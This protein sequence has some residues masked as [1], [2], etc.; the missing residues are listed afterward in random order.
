MT[1]R[2]SPVFQNHAVL[3]RDISIPIWGDTE[4]MHQVRCTFGRSVA[5]TVS[6]SSGRFE[7]RFP[8]QAAGGPHELIFE[9]LQSGE[10]VAFSDI[11]VGE[12]YVASGQSNIA[13]PLSDL[14]N[15]EVIKNSGRLSNPNIHY[16]KV[17]MSALP[18]PASYLDGEWTTATDAVS[19]QF[20]G[21]G[22]LFAEKIAAE[23]NIKV[24]IIEAARGG[25]AAESWMSREA[26]LR[27]PNWAEKVLE[28]DNILFGTGIYNMLPPGQLLPKPDELIMNRL[29]DQMTKLPMNRGLSLGYAAP[30]FDDRYWRTLELPDSW[31]LAGYIHG[32]I[33][34]FRLTLDLPKDCAGKE[35]TLSLGAVDK[36]DLTYFNGTE[37]GR[38]GD[39]IDMNFWDRPR[40]YTAPGEL[41][42]AGRNVI[43]IRVS[44][45]FPVA[46]SGGLTGPADLMFAKVGDLQIPLN[47]EWRYHMEHNAGNNLAESLV[48]SG[49]GEPHS[50]HILFDNMIAP[51]IPYAIRGVL[52]YQGECNAISQAAQYRSMLQSLIED[53]KYRW[54]QTR[55]DFIVIQLPGYQAKRLVSPHSQWALLRE[56]QLQ[57]GEPLVVTCDTGAENDIH[58]ADKSIIAE[59][60]A[61]IANALIN[62]RKPPYSPRMHSVT[63]TRAK[64]QVKFNTFGSKLQFNGE[65]DGFAIGE[66]GN[67]YRAKATIISDDTVELSCS[68]VKSPQ[69]L[70]YGW[71]NFPTGNLYNTEGLPA[72]PF[73]H[74]VKH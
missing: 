8:P 28:Y 20:S 6:N 4:P 42:K 64:L 30:D 38:T 51:L 43:A 16:F 50:Q 31:N 29:A 72:T 14:N 39:G 15:F 40:I 10:K 27:N 68:K 33:F 25:T 12:V 54:A 32:G 18:T 36:G 65:P 71:S 37:I 22:F 2:I 45:L 41:V 26:L 55:M 46:T 61:A 70:Y 73:R 60:A 7:L 48:M 11:W 66:K 47:V 19:P 3:Q 67:L 62:N 5:M 57:C 69:I 49:P 58:P 21:I 63:R 34:W 52:W 13:F 1:F 74:R 9:D 23:N 56:A 53:W 59:R 44:S 17:Q 24:G 35:L